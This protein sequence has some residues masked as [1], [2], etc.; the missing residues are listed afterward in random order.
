MG[1]LIVL[2]IIL[3]LIGLILFL[4][5]KSKSSNNFSKKVFGK[6]SA[7]IRLVS[8][9]LGCSLMLVLVVNSIQK[10]HNNQSANKNIT[11]KVLE[12]NS[13]MLI[14]NNDT[15]V[16]KGYLVGE[17]L[18]IESVGNLNTIKEHKSFSLDLQ[19]SKELTVKFDNYISL[20]INGDDLT[21]YGRDSR[22]KGFFGP[23]EYS[24][25]FNNGSGSG[26]FLL[27]K[28]KATHLSTSQSLFWFN[29]GISTH[30]WAL[31][32]VSYASESQKIHEIPGDDF[33]TK[34]EHL[35]QEK[36]YANISNTK[37]AV[38]LLEHFGLTIVTIFISSFLITFYFKHRLLIAPFILSILLL[39]TA[40]LERYGLNVKED[41]LLN[42][43]ESIRDRMNA[44][45][46]IPMTFFYKKSAKTILQKQ[47]DIKSTPE[48]LKLQIKI[49]LNEL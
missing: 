33:L 22:K 16:K 25:T 9:L 27:A 36:K 13:S 3:I 19:K 10:L 38:G 45:Q 46:K 1:F 37:H 24:Y 39:L 30:I 47:L 6:H 28:P 42:E 23:C 44:C 32:V 17:L 35:F 7:L 15:P 49:R 34:H 41:I 29:P 18:L 43:E 8:L 14:T 40:G 4:N 48:A 2:P 5:I 12:K 21:Y 26:G 31:W 11:L 20:T